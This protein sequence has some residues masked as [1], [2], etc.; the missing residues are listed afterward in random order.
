MRRS[1]G[2]PCAVVL[3]L[4]ILS[5][6]AAADSKRAIAV[7][8]LRARGLEPTIAEQVTDLVLKEVDRTGLFRTVSQEEIRRM[9]EHEQQKL[10]LGCEETSCLAEIGG[11]LGVDMLLAGG[12]GK[13]GETFVVTLKLIDVVKVEVIHREERMASGK[14]DALV[15]ISRQA[16]RALLR[17]IM[18]EESGLVELVCAEEGA[19]VYIDDVMVGTTPLEARKIPGGYHQIRVV[20][21]RFVAHGREVNVKPRDT[22]RLEVVLIPSRDFIEEYESQAT[23]Y[24]VF[25]WSFTGLAVASA[26]TAVG[27]FAWNTGRVDEYNADKREWE[28]DPTTHSKSDLDRRASSIHRVDSATIGI[29]VAAAASVGAALFFWLAGDPPGKYDDIQQAPA[30]TSVETGPLFGA[31]F[32]G[33]SVTFR[34]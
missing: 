10:M 12:V 28:A 1:P 5:C 7:L 4:L 31:R 9:L 26:G 3:S 6:P 34:Y 29:T 2:V 14:E 8:D 22:Q 25:A 24:R 30:P 11:A 16:A 15:Q 21:K 33:A 18:E 13:I 27:L 19:E 17:P 23:L 32:L 20:K